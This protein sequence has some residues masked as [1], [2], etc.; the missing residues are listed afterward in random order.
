MSFV[1]GKHKNMAT[2]SSDIPITSGT[3]V[4]QNLPKAFM[5]SVQGLAFKVDEHFWIERGL[6]Q[7]DA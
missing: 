1:I 7:Y 3:Q 2:D 5:P 6:L 4:F